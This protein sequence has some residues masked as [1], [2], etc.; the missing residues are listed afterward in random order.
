[1]SQPFIGEI[2]MFAGNFAPAGWEFCHG[3]LLPIAEHDALFTLIGTTYGGDGEE[4]F[5]LPNLCSRVPIHPGQGPGLQNYAHAE[6]AGVEQVTLTTHQIPVHSHTLVAS[7]GLA[8]SSNPEDRVLAQADVDIY[9]AD[10]PDIQLP[11]GS[12]GVV[13]GSQPHD[14]MSPFLVISF[15]ISIYG[16]FPTQT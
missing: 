12:I 14:N 9:V 8:N 3:Q 2:R 15:I 4:T 6:M 1:M 5:A 11:A 16:I 10:T 13:G 7:T